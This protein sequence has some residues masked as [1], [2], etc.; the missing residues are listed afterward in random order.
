MSE[1]TSILIRLPQSWK[2]RL[3]KAAEKMNRIHPGASYSA[4]SIAR[5]AIFD[6]IEEIEK[7]PQ[8]SNMAGEW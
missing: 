2:E 4:H 3:A 1:N 6:R 7:M 8:R 5:A